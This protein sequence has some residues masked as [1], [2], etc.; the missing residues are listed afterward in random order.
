[1]AGIIIF[2]TPPTFS[3]K[4]MRRMRWIGWNVVRQR[5]TIIDGEKRANFGMFLDDPV[6]K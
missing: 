5:Q 6:R 2:K 1:M 4:K 3:R